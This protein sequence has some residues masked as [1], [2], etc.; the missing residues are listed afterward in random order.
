MKCWK[1][2]NFRK[3][4]LLVFNILMLNLISHNEYFAGPLLNTADAAEILFNDDFNRLTGLGPNWTV[5]DGIFNT[6]GSNAVSADTQNWA[7]ITPNLGTNDYV[8]E[9]SIS[10]PPGAAYSGV[11]VRGNPDALYSDLYAAQINANGI[12]LY[13]RNAGIW[14]LLASDPRPF[15]ANIPEMIRFEVLGSNP[16]K[17]TVTVSHSPSRV[18]VYE[19]SSPDRILS[20]IPGVQN[21]N[22]NVKYD[23]F[24]VIKP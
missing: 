2:M 1:P 11:V 5:Y 6:D 20:G 10:F 4:F 16:V 21:Y 18:I 17:I 24:R 22:A 19:D 15:S 3:G 7:G 9:T 23:Y 14:T 8:V 12:R 13:R